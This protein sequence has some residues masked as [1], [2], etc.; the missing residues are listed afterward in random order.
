MAFRLVLTLA[1]LVVLAP[2]AARAEPV[3]EA[4]FAVT[5]PA[6]QHPA[7]PDF[8]VDQNGFAYVLWPGLVQKYSPGGA[9]V[10]TWG[11]YGSDPGQFHP[12]IFGLSTNALAVDS[13]GH[14]FV[15]DYPGNRVVEFTTDG[16]FVA[17]IG[18]FDDPSDV[19]V[20]AAGDL[21]VTDTGHLTKL[22]QDGTVL[23]RRSAWSGGVRPGPGNRVYVYSGWAIGDT[24]SW[25]DG[26]DLGQ[27]GAFPL[28]FG[29]IQGEKG[30]R[31]PSCCGIAYLNGRLWVARSMIH[32]I[33]AYGPNGGFSAACPLST[34]YAYSMLAG[35]DGRL[36]VS[37]GTGVIR[38]VDRGGPCDTEAPRVG[39]IYLSP[40]VL[41]IS[42]YRRLRNAFM[43]FGATEQSE[44]TLT[45]TRLVY[46]R[47]VS[48]RCV[49][50][51]R[52]NRR[53][54]TCLRR[55]VAE[56]SYGKIPVPLTD[57]AFV[58]F[59]DL[60]W[61]DRPPPGRY[62]LSIVVRDRN[63]MESEPRAT[64]VRLTR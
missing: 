38:Y 15:A 31:D 59:T 44:A 27:E 30:V 28:L 12:P 9:L 33:E 55:R 46:G 48:G 3:P 8:D 23:A 56:S 53:R 14:V 6:G 57:G 21:L 42:S 62:E 39:S 1:A 54:A 24:I 20:D 25:V 45:F 22:E 10:A 26:A 5:T 64:R 4:R 52:R 13:S 37:D 51:T 40:R 58:R 36:Y 61:K 29:D 60:F 50:P 34:S 47:R 7:F 18:G 11:S 32:D 41:R 35:R 49:R 16:A 43:V 17:N 19:A 2:A 63:G